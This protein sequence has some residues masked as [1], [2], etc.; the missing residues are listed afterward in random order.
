VVLSTSGKEIHI[1]KGTS[2]TV[3]LT[4]PVTVLVK[5]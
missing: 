4:A 2:L 3:R 5:G 1:A